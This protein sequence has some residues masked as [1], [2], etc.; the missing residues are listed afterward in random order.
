VDADRTNLLVRE[1]RRRATLVEFSNLNP[2]PFSQVLQHDPA[3]HSWKRCNRD[4]EE[5]EVED[6]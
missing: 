1:K 4:D 2:P 3:V 5:R 6:R